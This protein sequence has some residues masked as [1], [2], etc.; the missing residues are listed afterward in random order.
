MKYSATNFGVPMRRSRPGAKKK[1]VS[2]LNSR[3]PKSPWMKPLVM[4]V[5]YWRRRSS[6]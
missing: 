4:M 2:E 6:Q 5:S 1:N 3:W